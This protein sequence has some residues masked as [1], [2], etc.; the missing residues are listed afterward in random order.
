VPARHRATP[1]ETLVWMERFKSFL[2]PLGDA[3][4]GALFHKAE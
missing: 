3:L 2:A 4:G 1:A